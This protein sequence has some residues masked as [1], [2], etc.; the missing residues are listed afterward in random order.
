VPSLERVWAAG[1]VLEVTVTRRGFVGKFSRFRFRAGNVPRRQD[2][3]LA[4]GAAKPTR[5]PRR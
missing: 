4:P 5:C 1:P 3:C 2:L